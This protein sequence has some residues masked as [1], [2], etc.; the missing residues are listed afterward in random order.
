MSI[1][2]SSLSLPIATAAFLAISLSGVAVADAGV[3]GL[4]KHPAPSMGSH[5][6]IFALNNSVSI[7]ADGTLMNYQEHINPGPSD[8]ES[9]WMPGFKVAGSYMD[10]QNIYLH[11]G[12]AYNSGG[13]HYDGANLETHAASYTTDRATTQRLLGKIGYGFWLSPHMAITPYVAAG[14]QSWHRNLLI[15]GGQEIEDYSS[16]LAGVGALFQYQMT[17]RMILSADAEVLA[18]TGGG[19][20]PHITGISA[21]SAKFGTSGEEKLGLS[22]NYRIDGPFSVFGGL[23]FT[24]FTYTGGAMGKYFMEPASSTNR[25]GVNAG[26]RYSF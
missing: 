6:S 19:M 12:Y 25:F 11:L 21:P 22:A 15:T 18:V 2:K 3:W 5:S 14:F 1:K 17:P 20:T 23:S 13:I 10:H 9:G 8:T 4:N 24:H 7:A 16:P 26:V